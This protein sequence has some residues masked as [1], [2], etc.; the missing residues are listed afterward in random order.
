[1]WW[2]RCLRRIK[3]TDIVKKEL[4]LEDGQ[5]KLQST[6]FNDKDNQAESKLII[7]TQYR[8]TLDMIHEKLQKEGIKSVKFYG[9]GNTD[10]QK[11]L[12]QKEQKQIIKEFR[13]GKY[14]V[15]ISTSVAEEGIDIPVVDL[16]VLYEP[17]PF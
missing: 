2:G 9:Q 5:T 17:V 3:L 11:G 15:L 10:K 4:G 1:M 16:V 14:D 12:T 7:F 6:R 13:T 8:D